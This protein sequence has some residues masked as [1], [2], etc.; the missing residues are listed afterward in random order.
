MSYPITA[1]QKLTGISHWVEEDRDADFETARKVYK[2]DTEITTDWAATNAKLHCD[3]SHRLLALAS[4]DRKATSYLGK[5][6][7][8]TSSNVGRGIRS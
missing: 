7:V 3:E 2:S 8:N 5:T 1:G 6:T 4:K